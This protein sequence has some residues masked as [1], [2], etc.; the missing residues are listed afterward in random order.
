[1]PRRKKDRSPLPRRS[2]WR[3]LPDALW[4]QVAPLIPPDPRS[5]KGGR[6]PT[7]HRKILNGLLYVLRTGCQWKMMPC[8]YGS[9]STAHEHFQV[10]VRRGVFAELWRRCLMEYDELKGIDWQWQAVDSVTVA[11]PVKGGTA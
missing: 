5:P 10:W 4:A 9:S 7:D 3:D 1:M 6:P 11:A 8:E 2:G